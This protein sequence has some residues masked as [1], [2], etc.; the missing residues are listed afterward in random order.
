[1]FFPQRASARV[2]LAAT[3]SLI[4]CLFVSSISSVPALTHGGRATSISAQPALR[5][6]RGNTHTHTNNSDGDSSPLAVATR[7]KELGYNF[8]VLSDHNRL[9]DVDSINNSLA[10]ADQF[11]VMKGEEVTDSFNGKPVHINSINSQSAIAPQ[12]GINVLNTIDNDVAAITQAGGLAYVAHPNYGFAI[13]SEDLK[14]V[15]GTALFEI[16]NA[17]PVVNNGGDSNHP[18]VESIWDETLSSG[19]LRFGIAADDEHTLSNVSGALPGRAW[20]MVHAAS[21]DADSITDSIKRG[22]FYASTGVTLQDYQVRADGISIN[23][24]TG[25]IGPTTIDFIGK[26]G[27]LLQRDTSSSASY[28]FTGNEMYVRAKIVD[29]AGQVAW[30]QPVFTARLN[31]GNAILNAGSLGNEPQVSKAVSPDSVAIA[32]GLGLAAS[33]VEAERNVDGTFPTTLGGTTVTV[34][35]RSAE[36]YYASLSQV[37]FHI[38]DETELG[39]AQLVITNPDGVKLQSQVTIEPSA[40]GIFT[41]NGKGSGAAV[42][43]EA[44]RLLPKQFFPADTLRRCYI[45]A[46]G[47]RVGSQLTVLVNG[48]AVAVESVKECRRLP[49]LFQL[50]LALPSELVNSP[51]TLVIQADGKTSNSTTLQFQ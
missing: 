7:Y 41:E 21:L 39:V 47:I 34:N 42:K 2:A 32:F 18:S 14:N 28:T 5:W 20:V 8:V 48:Q 13:T 33:T 40:P 29:G 27:R 17:H 45:Y 11:L 30:T 10:E 3:H 6:Y 43:F 22:D 35:G 37:N 38:P 31:S 51:A 24:D 44:T 1:L 19:K 15:A 50:N 49:G 16:Y 26:G 25:S 46:T 4:F 36:I 12:H 9:T 23:L